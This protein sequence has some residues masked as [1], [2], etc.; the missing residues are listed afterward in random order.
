LN[1]GYKVI[2]VDIDGEDMD[3]G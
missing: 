1:H 2:R 3:K